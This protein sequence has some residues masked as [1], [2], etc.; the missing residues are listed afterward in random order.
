MKK[1]LI[2]LIVFTVTTQ[3]GYSQAVSPKYSNE[4]LSIGVGARG[5]GMS[6]SQAAN[7]QDVTAGYWNPAGLSGIKNKYEFSLM[8]A[9]YFAGIAKYDYAGFATAID[10]SS[11]L[12]ISLIRFAVDDIPDTRFLYNA[13]G[14]IDYN[15][16][17]FF[18]S[19]DYAFIFSYARRVNFLPGLRI[20][21]NFKI[22]H[23]SVGNFANAWGFGL[24][25]GAQLQLKQWQ[26]GVMV[27]D[28]TGTFNAW[29]HNSELVF[30]IYTQTGNEIPENSIE[31]TLPKAIFGVSRYF[32]VKEKFGILAS[33]DMVLSFDGRRNVILK[34]DFA[35]MDLNVGMEFDYLKTV[36]F[37]LGIGNI[38]EV[39]DFDESTYT[40]FQPNA[41]IGVKINKVII[42][43]ALTDIG[44]QSE[45]LYSHV[46]SIKLG[47]D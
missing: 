11:H 44:D 17:R 4:F 23:R 3:L 46:F 20:G 31:I 34:S 35:S 14:A 40:S 45:S 41:G 5:L 47:L 25:V 26:F 28:I 36:F 10:T 15:N 13:N 1:V 33:T 9:E 19:A 16:I 6:G 21:A 7:V 30:D 39:K 12:G 43:Y 18:S 38:Q 22:V 2:K 29:T 32:K 8:H 24:D 27:R 37:R 42:D